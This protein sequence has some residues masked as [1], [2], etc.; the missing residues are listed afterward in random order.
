LWSAFCVVAFVL[1]LF[2]AR[3]V[4]LQGVDENDYKA[5]A[6]TMGAQTI[7]LDATRGA[8]TDRFGTDLAQSVSASRL[9]ADPT[10]TSAHATEIATILHHSMHLD[11]LDTVD[12]LRTKDTR[13]VELARHLTPRLAGLVVS[14]LNHRNL[15]GVY[16]A[17]DTLRVYPGGDVAAN[18]LGFVGAENKGLYGLEEAFNKTLSGSDG[19]ATYQVEGGQILPLA[20]SH[21]VE[22][23][24]GTSIRLTLDQ[25]L[26]FLAQRR[27][28]QAVKQFDADSGSAIIMDARTS[29]VLALADYPTYNAN[30]FTD[31]DAPLAQSSALYDAYEPGSVEKVLTF[32][33][34][35]DAGYVSPTTKVVVPP[36]LPVG[37]YTVHDDFGHGTLH[38]TTAGVL[39]VSS[40]I[41]TVRS[42]SKMPANQLYGYLK[43]FGLG[44]PLDIGLHKTAVGTLTPPDTWP[45]IQRA[46]IDFGQGVSVNALQ[47]A[48]AI[49]AVAHGGLYTAP[50]LIQGTTSADGTFSPAAAPARHRVISPEAAHEVTRM[51]EA[52]VKAPGGTG[53][54][55]AIPGYRVAG[56]TGTAQRA[57]ATCHCYDG[58]NTVSFAGF[59][60]ADDPRFVI[61]V[62]VQNPRAANSFGATVAAPVFHDLMAAALQKYGVPPTGHPAPVLP[63]T[64]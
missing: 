52:V 62:V 16:T 61:Y 37:G 38:L 5:L 25:D 34:L 36:V 57:N 21:V 28:A 9:V 19:T 44:D 60:P 33:A 18:L 23:R 8:I 15:P 43:K 40:N 31:A 64:W 3:L 4:Q 63:T 46:D 17:H 13:Y 54:A 6:V 27:V 29:Q 55:A 48:T 59:A 35:I 53:P 14:R 56:K 32:S 26:Q 12:K 1:S 47:M 10:Y 51:M 39:A 22:P 24:D 50:S 45:E 41:G 11:Y 7:T 20:D 49:A 30:T 42:A 2:A 58:S